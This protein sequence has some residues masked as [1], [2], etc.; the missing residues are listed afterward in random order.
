[1]G[2]ALRYAIMK[3]YVLPLVEDPSAKPTYPSEA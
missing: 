2:N 1:M 3:K